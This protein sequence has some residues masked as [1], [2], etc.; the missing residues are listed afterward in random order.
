MTFEEY[1][2]GKSISGSTVGGFDISDND[3]TSL[4]GCPSTVKGE[5]HIGRNDLTSLEFCPSTVTKDFKCYSNDLTSLKHG[6]TKVGGSYYCYN[7]PLTSLE[8]APVACKSFD[9]SST[10]ITSLKHSP[11]TIIDSFVANNC[12]YLTTLEDAPKK[13]SLTFSIRGNINL[14][15]P[16]KQIL[17]Y[18]IQAF[19][20][21]TDDG[22]FT[23]ED[24]KDEFLAHS[25]HSKVQSKGFRA[26]LGIEK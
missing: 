4:K 10:D 14:K 5:C 12:A 13:M 1:N 9:C 21:E 2:D 19:D 16:K 25:L 24:I 26:L 8:G 6:P 11:R 3:L 17:K 22:N 20:Y 23:F 7:N 15:N 18:Q